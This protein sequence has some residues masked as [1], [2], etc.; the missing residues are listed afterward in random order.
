MNSISRIAA[1]AMVALLGTGIQ[2]ANAQLV[3][4]SPA[5]QSPHWSHITLYDF[6]RALSYIGDPT[7]KASAYDWFTQHIDAAE[8]NGNTTDLVTRNP[9]L[10]TSVY[11]LDLS[12]F[13]STDTANLPEAYFLHFSEDTQLRF[14]NMDGSENATITV[15]GCPT[16]TPATL[17]CR[18]Q[19]F[20]WTSRRYV[21]NLGDTAFRTWK[22]QDLLTGIGSRAN[23]VFLDE[24][25]P[26]FVITSSWGNQVRVLSG[27]A[28]REFNSQR[29]VTTG[30][31]VDTAYNDAM[32]G[33]LRYLAQ[34]FQQAG[35]RVVINPAAYGT[36]P[37]VIPQIQAANGVSTEFMHRPDSW[38]GAYQ[39]QQFQDMVKSVVNTGGVVDLHGTWC[40]GGPSGYTSGNYGS[41]IARY[42]MWQLASYYLMKEPIGSP[43]LVYF[44]P[45]F[46]SNVTVQ[47]QNDPSEWLAAYQVNIGDPVG[48][49]VVAQEGTA[50]VASTDGRPCA[51]KIW[52]RTYTKVTVFV[53]PKDMWDCTDYSDG[54]AASVALPSPGQMLKEDGTVGPQT[55]SISLRNGE[56]VIVYNLTGTTPLPNAKPGKGNGRGR[57]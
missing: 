19:T 39:Y 57:R 18:V 47:P 22:A 32:V 1:L 10:K 34:Q 27:G 48:Q 2:Q 13:A 29:V 35:K 40:Y 14:V 45:G 15:T 25:G 53:R 4:E 11:K 24:H 37:M 6:G 30:D 12:T 43:A 16:E 38:A 5:S 52:S 3:V 54:S 9:T 33:W 49:S 55:S 36:D 26:G 46:C 50:G 17:A 51:Y 20:I 41:A 28:I 31:P 42:H 7:A 21:H 56:A 44:D 8:S 23:E